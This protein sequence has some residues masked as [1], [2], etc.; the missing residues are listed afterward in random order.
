MSKSTA[1]LMNWRET[2]KGPE[3]SQENLD[4]WNMLRKRSIDAQS[5]IGM[6]P[7]VFEPNKLVGEA[8]A[9]HPAPGGTMP[10][11]AQVAE[12]IR[13]GFTGFDFS[14]TT[15]RGSSNI[16]SAS[17][18]F[19]NFKNAS[20]LGNKASGTGTTSTTTTFTPQM[21]TDL[22]AALQSLVGKAGW[23]QLGPLLALLGKG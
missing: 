17:D 10:T 19:S 15:P 1:D 14:N 16:A 13:P 9:E 18:F 8:T 6:M 7:G 2:Y 5:I 20:G 21:Q 23:E 22:I 11:E 12:F 4:F 3:Q